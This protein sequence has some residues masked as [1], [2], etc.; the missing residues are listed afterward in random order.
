MD[1]KIE[2]LV[3][4]IDRALEL[5]EERLN[6]I[7]AGRDDPSTVQG[8]EWIISAL[9]YRRKEALRTGYEVSETDLSLGLARAALE[10]DLSTSE[11]I[12]RIG[13]IEQYFRRYFVGHES[14]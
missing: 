8:M 6:G 7:R 14:K 3:R 10:Y 1:P 12:T 13:D 5:A 2:E 4:L 11:L 9:R